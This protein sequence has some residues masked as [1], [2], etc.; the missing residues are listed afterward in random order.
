MRKRKKKMKRKNIFE[1]NRKNGEKETK[2]RKDKMRIED[3]KKK[4]WSI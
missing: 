1:E 2:E 3:R 4:I